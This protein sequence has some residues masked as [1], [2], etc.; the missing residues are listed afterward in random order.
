MVSENW[1]PGRKGPAPAF[2]V[3]LQLSTRTFLFLIC[4]LHRQNKELSLCWFPQD[5]SVAWGTE[6]DEKQGEYE[7]EL[8]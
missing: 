4:F 6:W 8:D 7:A 5:L 3:H 2:S 1:G